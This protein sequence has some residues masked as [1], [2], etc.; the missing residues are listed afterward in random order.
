MNALKAI[1]GHS[2]VSRWDRP[3]LDDDEDGNED[4]MREESDGHDLQI[5]HITPLTRKPS[6]R[7]KGR[8]SLGDDET[9][10]IERVVLEVL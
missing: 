10:P 3:L 1:D 7:G 5:A 4:E 9:T 8:A 6:A 2:S